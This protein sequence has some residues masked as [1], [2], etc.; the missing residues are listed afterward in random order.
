M[1]PLGPV[2]PLRR[3]A[4]A[5]FVGT[6]IEYYD[7]S[8]YGTAAA[9]VFPRVFF[10][11]LGHTASIVAGFAAFAVAFFSRPLGAAFFG[12]FGDRIGRKKT[13]VATLLIMGLS[14][15][16]VGLVPS[17]ASIG[18]A[19]PGLVIALRLLQ[20]FAVGGEWA[21]A[22]LL[23]VEYAPHGKRGA[24]GMFTQLGV[25]AGTVLANIV[26]LIV[27][28]TIGEKNP[29]FMSWGWRVPFLFSALLVWIALF[30][31]LNMAET[32]VFVAEK[33][34]NAVLKIPLREL[35]H[36]Q[37][38]QVMLA[39][40]LVIATFT[41]GFMS[42]TYFAGYANTQ[43]GHPRNWVLGVGIVAGLVAMTT[44]ALSASLCDRVG[45]RR[46]IV[47][48]LICS[49]PWSF[50]VMPLLNTGSLV[51]FAVGIIGTQ[52]LNGA[53][54]GPLASFLPEIFATRYRYTGAGLAYN[55]G[56]IVGGAIPPIISGLLL[57]AF[58]SWAVGLM[59]AMAVSVSL[60]S[61]CFLPE[62]RGRQLSWIG[63][64]GTVA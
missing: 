48:G 43:L 44:V 37:H 45:R 56:G 42:N 6:A 18:I 33:E 52:A 25:G 20:G 3:V 2:T 35:F 1:P 24:Y 30:V 46:I 60:I 59:L 63:G 53:F 23:G 58:G 15:V 32:P 57:A 19:A 28:C 11:S 31:R 41:F 14:T 29:I 7:F 47:F 50:A 34:N 64:S 17:A 26:F 8:V 4:L 61:A 9:L 10:P 36:Q 21:G 62:T 55:L 40:G 22:A 16:A 12:H 49:L 13:L 51:L 38:R 5:S 54:Y 27:N 39:A